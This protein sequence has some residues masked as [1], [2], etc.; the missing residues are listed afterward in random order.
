MVDQNIWLEALMNSSLSG[1]GRPRVV[2]QG[3]NSNLNHPG[4][5]SDAL[6]NS[7]LVSEYGDGHLGF[8]TIFLIS[9]KSPV[10]IKLKHVLPPHDLRSASNSP[11]NQ[12]DLGLPIFLLSS[13]ECC[14]SS[15]VPP[16]SVFILSWRPNSGLCAL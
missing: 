4:P 3:S 10:G 9:P 7:R 1:T 12:N 6:E 15:C 11:C 14:D 2:L 5:F 16:H 8:H 13:L